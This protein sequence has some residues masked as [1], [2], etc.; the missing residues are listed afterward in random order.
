MSQRLYRCAFVLIFV[1]L[2]AG[3]LLAQTGSTTGQIAGMV[4]D[5]SGAAL[6]GVTVTAANV[7]TGLTRQVVTEGDGSYAIS[8]LPP[9]KYRVEAE[10]EGMGRAN[11]NNAIVLLGTA[12]RVDL[13][14]NPSLSQEITVTA[15]LPLID[16]TESDLT[17]SVT[18]TQIENLP[19]LGRDFRDLVLLTPGVTDTFNSGVSLN[20]ARGIATDYNVDGA[21]NNSDFFGQQRGGSQPP[22]T[23]S[24]AAIREF[25]VIRSSYSAEYARGV[26]ATLN[27]VTKSGTNELDGQVF[28]YLRDKDWADDRPRV[29]NGFS[30][31]ESFESR[32]ND[33]YGFA[34]GGP[35][36]RDRVHFFINTD[37]QDTSIPI[38]VGDVR[39]DSD[40]LALPAAT[41]AAFISR[42]EQLSG[43]G[44]DS[45]FNFDTTQ[46][47]DTYL[48]KIDANIGQRHHLSFRDNYS[49]FNQFAN[50]GASRNLLYQGVATNRFNTAVVQAES[51]L[52]GS[53]FNQL[54][55]QYS[56]EDRPIVPVTTDIPD[57]NIS[58]GGIAFRF[59]Q[60]D[61]LPNNTVEKT[62]EIKDDLQY[63]WK[64]HSLKTGFDVRLGRY[65][66]LFARDLAGEFQYT[67]IANFLADKPQRFQQGL[68]PGDAHNV[69]DRDTYGLFVHDTWKP[70]AKLTLDLGVRYDLG[71]TPKPIGNVTP[72]YPEFVDNF[73]EDTDNVAPRFGFAWDPFANGKS[74]LRGGVGKYYNLL[75][76][77][78][79]A[80]P[81]AQIGGIFSNID[82][83]CAT[84]TCPT[85]PNLY[86]PTQFAANARLSSDIAIVGPDL[87][88]QESLRTSLQFEQELFR[89]YSVSLGGTYSKIEKAQ[90][91]VNVNA[92][93]V[94]LSGTPLA[95]GDLKVYEVTN[96]NR[97]YTA[98]QNV[99]MHVSDAEGSYKS[100]TIEGKK[101]ALADQKLSL[102]AHYTWAE[103]IDQ[104]SNERSTSTS[105]SLDP[106]DPKL[107]E[108]RADYDVT[109]RVLLSATYALPFDIIVSGIYV[110]R[111]GAPYTPVVNGLTNG[112]S[113]FGISTPVFLDRDGKVIDLTQANGLDRAGLAAFLAGQGAHVQD[114]NTE[115]QPDFSNL[116]F[117]LSKKFGIINGMKIELI[118]RVFNVLNEKNEFITGGNQDVFDTSFTSNKFTFTPDAKFGRTNAYNNL[119]DPRQYEVAA[120]FIF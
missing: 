80:N 21:T 41:Q 55:L 101:L 120:K 84:S 54:I 85:Y 37:V 94:V 42:V 33:Q 68:G 63:I 40:F 19:I 72:Q 75:P 5:D 105:F 116:D 13:K 23:F 112:L 27:A 69:Y 93:Q 64:S 115:E 50:Q 98:F 28:Y 77:I 51:V 14:V 76:A 47:Q 82:V 70:S 45:L 109:H 73:N 20:G 62:T 22:F 9:G 111:T 90:R 12:T 57:T 79:L 92:T 61:F 7:E 24:Q 86:N 74:V 4:T 118:G 18:Q 46:D 16:G 89:G 15:A 95:Y 44:F 113:S 78:I 67:S 119:S 59:G 48:A 35:I 65:D 110:W 97:R 83:V 66:N 91:F 56:K 99:R 106:F 1:F 108:G 2:A 53:L 29:I 103:A 26:G 107:S 11:R 88:A 34:F 36:V 102:N 58:G 8:L 100:V 6:P 117:Q 25:Q 38:N 39:T 60:V 104:D 96:P 49:K 31:T 10:L 3:A 81:L 17:T 43:R 32:D 87:E 114:R 30:V 71:S 52:T